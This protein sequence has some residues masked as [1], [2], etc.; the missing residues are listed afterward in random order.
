MEEGW[1]ILGFGR[2]V[3]RC[4]LGGV[5]TC[6]DTWTESGSCSEPPMVEWG[7]NYQIG[8]TYRALVS[9]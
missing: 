7:F 2:G 5:D 1:V 8:T 3:G 4:P 6:Q 9:Q